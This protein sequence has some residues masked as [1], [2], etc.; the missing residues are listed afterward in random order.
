MDLAF[1]SSKK[2]IVFKNERLLRTIT[3]IEN[4]G[5]VDMERIYIPE[6]F[7]IISHRLPP[8]APF[9][10]FLGLQILCDHKDGA[11]LKWVEE[12][13]IDSE[14]AMRDEI[15]LGLEKHER[16]QFQKIQDYFANR[17]CNS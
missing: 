10:F 7:S 5:A 1:K 8:M 6:N 17:Q 12:F 13:E 4:V 11:L 15:L 9:T 2:E 16:I 3:K 14:Y